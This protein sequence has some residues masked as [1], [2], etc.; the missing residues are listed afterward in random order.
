M[1]LDTAEDLFAY[2]LRGVYY[3]EQRLLNLLDELQT[4]ATQS[5]LVDGFEDHREETETHVE[6]LERVFAIT[7]IDLGE[8]TVPSFDALLREKRA[9]D[10]D[11]NDEAVQNALYDHLGRK[12]ERLELTT[13]EGLLSLADALDVDR[14]AVDLLERNRAEDEAALAE[15]EAVSEG[16]QFRS[17][18]DRLL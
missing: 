9:Y 2:Q 8:Q 12:A 6:R 14:E 4:S 16:G 5:S 10:A 1:S 11:A 17:F 3:V 7:G 15:L 18:V 13:Y